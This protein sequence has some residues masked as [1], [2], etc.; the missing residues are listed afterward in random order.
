MC[1][2]KG[3]DS[4]HTNEFQ[5]LVKTGLLEGTTGGD[6][7]LATNP[8]PGNGHGG[9]DVPVTKE[10]PINNTAFKNVTTN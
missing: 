4:K 3:I 10:N 7:C 8:A 6:I 5:L 2:K 9:L 1:R